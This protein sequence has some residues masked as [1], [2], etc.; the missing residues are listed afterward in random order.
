M[1]L[2]DVLKIAGGVYNT[3]GFK[4]GKFW[5]AYMIS[6]EKARM[7]HTSNLFVI[8][9]SLLDDGQSWLSSSGKF[10]TLHSAMIDLLNMALVSTCTE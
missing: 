5:K 10:Q 7:S 4:L 8:S 2:N 9:F 6:G 1:N 3:L